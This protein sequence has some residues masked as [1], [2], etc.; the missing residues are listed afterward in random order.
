MIRYGNGAGRSA[1]FLL[2]CIVA[3]ANAATYSVFLAD[4]QRG[5]FI[6]RSDVSGVAETELR[7]SDRFG[8]NVATSRFKLD[9]RGVLRDL[10]IAGHDSYGRPIAERYAVTGKTSKWKSETDSGSSPVGA[11][12]LPSQF[13]AEHLAAMTRALLASPN[14]AMDLLPH[15][16]ARA[17]AVASQTVTGPAGTKQVRLYFLHGLDVRPVS[18]WLDTDDVLF[19]AGND[20]MSYILQG[21]ESSR[22]MLLAQ[23]A[24]ASTERAIRIARQVRRVPAG[25]VAIRGADLFDPETRSLRHDVTVIVRN[26]LIETVGPRADVRIPADAEIVEAAGRTLLPGLIDMHVHIGNPEDA[27]LD[28]LA[29][30]T[31]VRD[32]GGDDG[33]LRI[34]TGQFESGELAGPRVVRVG[35]IEG[36]APKTAGADD[37]ANTPEQ[38]RR[39]VDRFADNGYVQIKIYSSFKPELVP[40]AVAAAHARDL[41]VSGHIPAGMTMRQA[42]EAGFDEV[43][44]ANFWLLNFMGAEIN[45][46]T[47]TPVR[48]SAA[49]EH[50]HEIDPASDE[51][52]SFIELLRQRRTIIDPT[53]VI[54]EN[55]FTAKAGE[56]APSVAPFAARLPPILARR[57]LRSGLADN[58]VAAKTYA[59]SFRRLSQLLKQ[60][61]DA[62]VT[63]VPGTDDF[64]SMGLAREL[65]LY[66][67]AGVPTNE[68]L[69]MVTLGAAQVLKRDR[70]FG[71]V[72]P[73]KSADLVLIDGDPTRDI[74]NVRNTMLVMR[75]GA[76]YDPRALADVTGLK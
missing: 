60:I 24:A 41:P 69:R 49:A 64:F 14:Q 26:D 66:V 51:T 2:G 57:Y 45:A 42:V 48:F 47:N 32:L 29:G 33:R 35:V 18:V 1:L 17:E 63:I 38:V 19:A 50:G 65:E 7:Y 70:Q 53:L 16:R 15:G 67:A 8:E 25:P 28:L 40:V 72:T 54:Y 56:P 58:P 59:E 34:L 73:G 3:S 36:G 55:F 52:R 21:H 23:Q 27:M 31:T 46:K 6:T 62:G 43:H 9:E 39:A 71:S 22:A 5:T 61:Y 13:D 74:G 44:H 76:I 11:F 10:E 37:L 20:R 4:T 30:V 75:S 12:Y 68:V